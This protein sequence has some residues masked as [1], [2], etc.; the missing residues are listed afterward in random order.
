MDSSGFRRALAPGLEEMAILCVI[1]RQTPGITICTRRTTSR[2]V[3]KRT[4]GTLLHSQTF[5]TYSFP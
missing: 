2:S 3:V 5:Y 1:I 4:F